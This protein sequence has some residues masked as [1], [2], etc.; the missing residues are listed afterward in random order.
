MWFLIVLFYTEILF[1]FLS[2]VKILKNKYSYVAC[3]LVCLIMIYILN[4]I[5]TSTKLEIIPASLFF[6]ILGYLLNKKIL[7]VY[8]NHQSVMTQSLLLCLPVVCLCS[9]YNNPVWM[10]INSYGNPI[11]FITGACFGI[12]I[13][14]TMALSINSSSIFLYY[15]RNSIIIY[16]THFFIVD[17]VKFII[18]RILKFE[19]IVY[20][21]YCP[22]FFITILVMPL[23]IE[24]CNKYFP[25]L[26]GKT[27]MK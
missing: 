1:Y 14:I 20:P 15:G 11:L 27:T 4:G 18:H 9:Y 10:Y 26:F 24:I 8:Y 16:I 17:I 22:I 6:Y 3:L 23:I 12:F 5:S 13:V 7:S 19:T 25:F 2:K 21:F